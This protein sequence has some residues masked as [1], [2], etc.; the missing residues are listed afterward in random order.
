MLLLEISTFRCCWA[1]SEETKRAGQEVLRLLRSRH[2]LQLNGLIYH[3]FWCFARGRNKGSMFWGTTSRKDLRGRGRRGGPSHCWLFSLSLPLSTFVS[4]TQ[5]FLWSRL[6]L[7]NKFPLI[8]SQTQTWSLWN[9]NSPL[10]RLGRFSWPTVRSCC[11]DTIDSWGKNWS[12]IKSST[13]ARQLHFYLTLWVWCTLLEYI[14][15]VS[16]INT[17]WLVVYMKP[18]TYR[19]W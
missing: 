4:L 5:M 9:A 1:F 3:N 8:S 18:L 19:F 7:L 2:S 16:L 6:S 14:F 10:D 12:F 11:Q 15:M 17:G 13:W